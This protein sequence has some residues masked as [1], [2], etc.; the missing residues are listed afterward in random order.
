[1]LCVAFDLDD[2]LYLERSYVLSGF[3]AAGVWAETE[4]G[5]PDLTERALHEFESGG[6][7]KVFNRVLAGYGFFDRHVLGRLVQVYR[8]H[9]PS[10]ALLPDATQCLRA[11]R[12]HAYLALITDGPAAAQREKVR[13]LGLHHGMDLVVLTGAWGQE[14]SK[15]NP[16]A[17]AYVQQRFAVPP[18]CC[19]YIGDNPAK[20]FITPRRLG[21]RTVRVRREG[22][23]HCRRKPKTGYEAERECGDL[24]PVPAMLI[25]AENFRDAK[26]YV[27]LDPFR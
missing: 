7:G 17:F 24:T 8:S 2:T 16:R 13:A 23:L 10:I 15:P 3:R 5:I 22:G 4:L 12:P 26:L 1:M 18:E 27:P 25:S 9:T 14:F 6:R 19:V 20:D 11:L 21:W